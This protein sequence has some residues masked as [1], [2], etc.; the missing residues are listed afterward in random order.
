[1]QTRKVKKHSIDSLIGQAAEEGECLIWQ[2]YKA[3][4]ARTPMV[5]ADLNGQRR[6]VSVRG[7][8]HMMLNEETQ[9]RDGFYIVTCGNPD[10][11]NPQHTRHLSRQQHNLYM[12]KRSE[13]SSRSPSRIAKIANSKRRLT[14]EQISTIRTSDLSPTQL[15]PLIGVSVSTVSAYRRGVRGRMLGAFAGLLAFSGLSR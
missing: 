9:I 8:L 7:L 15:A 5:Y 13:K 3:G 12:N 6:M 4:R 10:C 11:I 1:M 14:D 2:G